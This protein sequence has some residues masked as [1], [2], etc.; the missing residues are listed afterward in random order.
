LERHAV[1]VKQSPLSFFDVFE[2]TYQPRHG[3]GVAESTAHPDRWPSC[4]LPEST[5]R[6]IR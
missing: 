1:R 3:V 4:A 5:G 2:A 6:G